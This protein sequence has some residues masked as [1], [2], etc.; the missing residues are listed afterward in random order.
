MRVQQ[1]RCGRSCGQDAAPARPGAGGRT[2]GKPDDRTGV[3]A[4]ACRGWGARPLAG[5]DPLADPVI[6]ERCVIDDHIRT[7]RLAGVP[8]R[9]AAGG[10][11]AAAGARPV[12]RRRLQSWA[13]RCPARV[14]PEPEPAGAPGD[15][16][17][18]RPGEPRPS[19][20]C[21]A[22]APARPSRRRPRGLQA[23]R[24]WWSS[25]LAERQRPAYRRPEPH[26]AAHGRDR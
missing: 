24:S 25:G 23:R 15:G 16:P 7:P 20:Q 12:G 5:H 19:P 1:T 21:V 11:V 6:T 3:A 2:L 10:D 14:R 18:T 4:P 17:R 13:G 9:R 8:S 22:A 26:P